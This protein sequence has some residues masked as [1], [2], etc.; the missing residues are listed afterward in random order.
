MGGLYVLYLMV[1]VLTPRAPAWLGSFSMPLLSSFSFFCDFPFISSM[2][3][4]AKMYAKKAG[5]SL[6]HTIPVKLF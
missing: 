5:H 1:E 2:C 3:C 6:G 4:P